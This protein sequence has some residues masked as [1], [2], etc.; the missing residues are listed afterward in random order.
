MKK[1]TTVAALLLFG[2]SLFSQKFTL[3]HNAQKWDENR[4]SEIKGSPYFFKDFVEGD[5]YDIDG[6]VSKNILLNLNG[7]TQNI[8]LRKGSGFIELEEPSYSKVEAVTANKKGDMTKTVFVTTDIAQFG[9]RFVQLVYD[10]KKR[11]V[12]NDFLATISEHKTETPGKTLTIKRFAPKNRYFMLEN[13]KLVIFK[14][15]KKNVIQQLGHKKE[16]E[17]FLKK[18]KIKVESLEGIVKLLEYVEGLE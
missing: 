6:K 1:Y 18:N 11:K 5:I 13:A 15:K 2:F 12:Y 7:Y 3:F 4:Y 14:L 17:T 9:G 16:I 10:G 8:E